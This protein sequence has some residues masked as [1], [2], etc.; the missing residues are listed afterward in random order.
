VYIDYR[1]TKAYRKQPQGQFT[2]QHSGETAICAM[3]NKEK[4]KVSKNKKK[5][6]I[7]K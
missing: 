5:N 2:K 3:H 1:K 7:N 4:L 6:S